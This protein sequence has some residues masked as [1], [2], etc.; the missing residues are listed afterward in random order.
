MGNILQNFFKNVW[1]IDR[2]KALNE[3]ISNGLIFNPLS[4]NPTKW[5]KTRIRP[6]LSINCLS[7]LNYFVGL[8]LKELTLA[9]RFRSFGAPKK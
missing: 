2:L 4:D 8:A 7:V 6:L 1:F 9:K 5:S 3:T